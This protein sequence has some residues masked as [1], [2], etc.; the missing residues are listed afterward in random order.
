[1]TPVHLIHSNLWAGLLT[2]VFTLNYMFVS[3]LPSSSLKEALHCSL[4]ACV[5]V[6]WWKWGWV[7]RRDRQEN[8]LNSCNEWVTVRDWQWAISSVKMA[9]Y[10]A[11]VGLVGINSPLQAGEDVHWEAKHTHLLPAGG[12]AQQQMAFPVHVAICA[13]VSRD[14]RSVPVFL[15]ECFHESQHINTCLCEGSKCISSIISPALDHWSSALAI[16]KPLGSRHCL[17]RFKATLCNFDCDP[18]LWKTKPHDAR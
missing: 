9:F 12:D 3:R 8:K 1:M 5:C 16:S 14:I 7:R 10:C 11:C 17:L 4:T 13:G 2:D 6:R 18:K 15:L